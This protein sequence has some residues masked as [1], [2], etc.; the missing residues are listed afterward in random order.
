ME[1]SIEVLSKRDKRG[2]YV[3]QSSEINVVGRDIKWVPPRKSDIIINTDNDPDV[4][5]LAIEIIES[6]KKNSL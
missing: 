2:L 1:A 4:N 5:K 3:P 6:I